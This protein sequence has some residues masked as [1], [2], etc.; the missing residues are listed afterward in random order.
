MPQVFELKT[1]SF[2]QAFRILLTARILFG[3]GGCVKFIS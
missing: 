2:W 1:I 3:S